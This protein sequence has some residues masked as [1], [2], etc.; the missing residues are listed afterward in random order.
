MA[1]QVWAW[2]DGVEAMVVYARNQPEVAAWVEM[3]GMPRC[4]QWPPRDP[5]EVAGVLVRG[6][7]APWADTSQ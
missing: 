3:A 4:E 5:G 6:P 2:P 7:G 1:G